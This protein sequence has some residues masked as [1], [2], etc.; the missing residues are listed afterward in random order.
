MSDTSIQASTPFTQKCRRA[1]LIAHDARGLNAGLIAMMPELRA[2]ALRLSADRATADDLVQD[3]VERALKFADQYQRGTNLRAW[4]YQILFSV[5]VTRY[6]RARRERSALRNLASD[7]CAWTLPERFSPPDA[8]A[9]LTPSTQGEL[10]ALPK[11]FR[12]VLTLVDLEQR[13][14]REAATALGLPVGTVM[15]RLHRGR[16]LLASRMDVAA[17]TCRSKQAA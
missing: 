14:Y 6:R 16:K 13:S 8:T 5:F 1:P 12:T 2:R 15:S 7:P 10:D 11:G 3:T 4:A 17:A 9:A